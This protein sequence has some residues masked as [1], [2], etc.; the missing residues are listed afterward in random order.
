VPTSQGYRY[1]VDES[2]QSRRFTRSE[3]ERLQEDLLRLE[4]QYHLLARRTAKLLAALTGNLAIA[5]VTN[6][7]EFHEAGLP[8]LLEEPEFSAAGRVRDISRVLDALDEHFDEMIREP[9]REPR[10]YIGEE[11]P[12][13]RT[14]HVSML[15]TTCDLPSGERGLLVVIGPTRMRYDRN[16]GL[17]EQIARLLEMPQGERS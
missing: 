11:N 2:I 17:L 3:V 10:V 5:G 14:R 12:Y 1:F 6:T 9:I 7:E 16:I 13:V 8:A 15:L 4:A